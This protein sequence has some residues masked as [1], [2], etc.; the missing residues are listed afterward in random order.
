MW[1]HRKLISELGDNDRAIHFCR[2]HGLLP[3]NRTCTG[4]INEKHRKME[5]TF[6]EN[7]EK[8]GAFVCPKTECRKQLSILKDTWF[9]ELRIPI[10]KVFRLG[11]MGLH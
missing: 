9:E 10:T 8:Y 11:L 5:M 7:K 3:K 1:N 6:Y 2:H 4:K